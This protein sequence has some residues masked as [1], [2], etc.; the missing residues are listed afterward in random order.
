M[1]GLEF[2]ED[3]DDIR[4]SRFMTNVMRS[5]DTA[6]NHR[7]G[8]G[9]GFD[10]LSEP[11]DTHS[12]RRARA[13]YEGRLGERTMATGSV[14]ALDG[15][16]WSPLLGSARLSHNFVSPIY[17]E[18]A[19]ERS[20]VD[21]IDAIEREIEIDSASLSVDFGPFAGWT[22]V[23]AHTAQDFSDGNQRDI[24]VGRVIY[25]VPRWQ[26]LLLE[27]RARNIRMDFDAPEYFSPERLDERLGLVT[28][29][30][31][32]LDER[33]FLSVQAGAGRQSINSG[34]SETI[35]L[36][37]IQW[38]GWFSNHWGLETGAG[39]RNTVNLRARDPDSYRYC[40]ANISL[41]RS[42]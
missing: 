23:G 7:A 13:D 14:A 40:Q 41:L 37:E 5:L 25:D 30:R 22:L 12:F 4:Q 19:A 26:P 16:E 21:T 11:D 28:W 3:S 29:R 31:A 36:G 10:R 42:W 2:N 38:R 34:P 39:C 6:G 27:V 17:A 18:I 24:T 20:Y 35:Y 32:V 33:W 15:A 1:A 9:I 8:V